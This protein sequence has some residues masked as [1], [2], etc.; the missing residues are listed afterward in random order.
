MRLPVIFTTILSFMCNAYVPAADRTAPERG[1][2][3]F[4]PLPDTNTPSMYRLAA[5]NFDFELARQTDLPVSGVTV[6]R[7]TFPS[8]VETLYLENNTVHAE[9]FVPHGKGPFPAVIVLEILAGGDGMARS[10]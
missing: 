2:V 5:H 1:T 10:M 6:H 8:P 7:L 4:A 9:Y 3:A